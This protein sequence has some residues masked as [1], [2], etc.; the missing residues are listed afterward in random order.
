[1]SKF[2]NYITTGE[3]AAIFDVDP[4]EHTLTATAQIVSENSTIVDSTNLS[5]NGD[6][7]L[8]NLLLSVR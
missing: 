4:D 7:I 1:M 5:D 3:A 2:K 6:G 8:K